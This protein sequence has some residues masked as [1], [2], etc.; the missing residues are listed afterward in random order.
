MGNIDINKKIIIKLDLSNFYMSDIQKK[1]IISQIKQYIIDNT[2]F[3]GEFSPNGKIES[4]DLSTYCTINL[5]RSTH[6]I[7]NIDD[8]NNIEFVLTEYG[9]LILSEIITDTEEEFNKKFMA[10]PRAIVYDDNSIN[11][12]TIDLMLKE[13]RTLTI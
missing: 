2:A 11:L 4:F 10:I 3:F 1:E 13:D 5:L 7:I 6:K 12:I 9:N 8:D